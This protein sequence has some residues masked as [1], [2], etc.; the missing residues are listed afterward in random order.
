MGHVNFVLVAGI[1]FTGV[2]GPRQ[3]EIAISLA[4]V[5]ILSTMLIPPILAHIYCKTF[6]SF[7]P[8]DRQKRI[9]RSYDIKKSLIL[10][11][12]LILIG[13]VLNLYFIGYPYRLFSS[14][15]LFSFLITEIVISVLPL[16]IGIILIRIVA[17]EFDQQA[18]IGTSN[19]NQLS[20]NRNEMFNLQTKLLLLP[21]VPMCLYY[22]VLDSLVLMPKSV[23]LFLEAHPWVAL[24]LMAST[25]LAV[26][27]YA[28]LLLGLL[29][30]TY[31]LEN[32]KLAN[33][34][35]ELA[36]QNGIKYGGIVVWQTGSLKIANA[37][38]AGL[39]PRS[40]KIFL[41]DTLLENFSTREVET[42]VAHEFGHIHYKHIWTY[43]AFSLTY[44]FSYPLL[45]MV[46]GEPILKLF[47]HS[48]FALAFYTIAFLLMFFVLI[49]PFLSRRFEHQA[50]L[51][52][53]KTTQQPTWFKQALWH[54]G[55]I[56]FVPPS[57]RWFVRLFSTHPSIE[58]RLE[59]IDRACSDDPSTHRYERYLIEA[60]ILL[61]L[62]P[63]LI[64][65]T[66]IIN[67]TSIY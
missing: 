42:V 64:C 34:L 67:L 56:N 49:F 28:P 1:I 65:L 4:I 45:Y 66:Q 22:I 61:I 55:G 8:N 37:A 20:K 21:L 15:V 38:V 51:Y 19:S 11:E 44:F 10:F 7:L 27:I 36:R 24:F 47:D 9:Q 2:I 41:T 62:L 26:F 54:L 23:H 13:Y 39:L 59:F 52:A 58:N 3:H 35:R 57:A 32:D 6:L 5:S 16:L 48:P 63:L 33:R 12:I 53:I 43:F 30:P 31:P 14:S 25:I 40:R 50:D 46:I 60:K 29:W 17:F 18:Q